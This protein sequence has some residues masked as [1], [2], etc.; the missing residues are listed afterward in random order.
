MEKLNPPPTRDIPVLIGGGGEKKT[1]RYV[2][3][4]ADMWHYF[5]DKEAYLRKVAILD[6]HCA[7]VGRDPKE[8]EHSAGVEVRGGS[9]D[10]EGDDD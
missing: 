4:H 8:I 3:E 5:V 7:A 6:E 10:D 2:A 1:L 9:V